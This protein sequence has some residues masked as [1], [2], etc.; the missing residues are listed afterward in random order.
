MLGTLLKEI[1]A[2]SGWY[3]LLSFIT[4]T[5]P[6]QRQ[7][8]L[9]VIVSWVHTLA[10]QSAFISS[11]LY[12]LS[13]AVLSV[14]QLLCKSVLKMNKYTF[15][16]YADMHLILNKT[17]GN[18]ATA[19]RVHT[20]RYTQCRLLNPPTFH[21]METGNVC[22]SMVYH[23]R[24]RTAWTVYLEECILGHIEDNPHISSWTCDVHKCGRFSMKSC[25]T[26]TI[27]DG[28]EL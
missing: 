7:N 13:H 26:H 2:Y 16:E 5:F 12:V 18:G 6:V 23:G 9:T 3:E 17:C 8:M 27:Y 15:C 20:D 22:S 1:G 10:W 11:E 25:S 4:T 19:V 21:I 14:F 28:H 24:Q